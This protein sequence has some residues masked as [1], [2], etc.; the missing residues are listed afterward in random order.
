LQQTLTGL[1]PLWLTSLIPL[2]PTNRLDGTDSAQRASDSPRTSVQDM[3]V[4]H[5]GTDVGVPEQFLNRA[6]IVAIFEQI[7][8]KR[9]PH[10]VRAGRFR[11]VGRNGVRELFRS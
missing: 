8:S 2:W 5:C 1:S 11:D 4:N 9:M 6:D 7:G 10:G 3:G